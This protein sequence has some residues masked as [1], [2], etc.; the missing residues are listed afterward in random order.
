[1]TNIRE[2]CSG[3]SSI[4][5]NKAPKEKVAIKKNLEIYKKFSKSMILL[6]KPLIVK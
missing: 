1:M 4:K 3:E 6:G 2:R 5:L